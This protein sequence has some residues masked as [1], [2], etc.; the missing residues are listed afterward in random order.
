MAD[1]ATLGIQIKSSDI[2]KA[3]KALDK[4][5]ESAE[6][7]EKASQKIADS[8]SAYVGA[9]KTAS[10]EESKRQKS[11]DKMIESLRQQEIRLREG[12]GALTD[13][14]LSLL[15]ATESERKQAQELSKKIQLM[16]ESNKAIYNHTN[17]LNSLVSKV[18]ALAAAYFSLNS[19][20]NFA[21][22]L[23]NTAKI[24]DN[25]KYSLLAVSD[26]GEQAAE[27]YQYLE[28]EANRL[29]QSM[30][31]NVDSFTGFIASAKAAGLTAEQ[32]R[33]IYTGLNE[34]MTALHRT[35][36]QASQALY[37]LQQMLASGTVRA[38]ELNIQLANAIPGAVP[39]FAQA[40]GKTTKELRD[41]MKDGLVPAN[42]AVIQFTDYLSGK[43]GASA[44]AA[45]NSVQGSLNKMDNALYNLKK[46]I[47]DAMGDN[48]TGIIKDATN[49]LIDFTNALKT[50]EGKQ[51]I[52]DLSTT[53]KEAASGALKLAS[54]L[55]SVL[56]YANLR[57]LSGTM[58]QAA[59]LSKKGMLDI[60]KF[61]TSS[62][63]ERQRMV[64]D[65]LK[66]ESELQ[67]AQQETIKNQKELLKTI[68]DTSI[69]T[70]NTGDA[71][72]RGWS[73][74]IGTTTQVTDKMNEKTIKSITEKLQEQAITAGKTGVEKVRAE[75]E[76]AN[77]T[78]E[79]K[80]SILALAAANE[81]K[82]NARKNAEKA[83]RKAEQDAEAAI[84]KAEAA[85]K[86]RQGR[87]D[88]I[89][90][91]LKDQI[92]TYKQGKEVSAE[93]ALQH[94][95]ATPQIIEYAKALGREL[96]QMKAIN[97]AQKEYDALMAKTAPD[98]VDLKRNEAIAILNEQFK[99][100][101]KNAD[102][103]KKSLKQINDY[104]DT[105]EL[106]EYETEV[107]KLAETIGSLKTSSF[108]NEMADGI[109]NAVI[110][111]R[112]LND[113]LEKNKDTYDDIKKKREEAY[114]IANEDEREKKIKELDEL[115]GKYTASQLSGYRQLFGTIS[116]LYGENTK[117]REALHKIEMAFAAA[118][119]AMNLQ[120]TIS[121]AYVA[122]TTQGAGD[123]YTAFAR[124]A[125]MTA[126]MAGIVSAAGG[127]LSGG[128]SGGGAASAA[129]STSSSTVLGGTEGSQSISN[130]LD[131]MT[132]I[133]SKQYN[134]LK[135]INT[136]VESLNKNITGLV[137]SIVRNADISTVQG[138]VAG[139]SG[140]ASYAQDS[141]ARYSSIIG[142]ATSISSDLMK[143]V[144]IIGNLLGNIAGFV[145]DAVLGI[146]NAVFG[147]SKK[148]TILAQGLEVSTGKIS[149]LLDGMG[150]DIQKFA[151]IKVKK[152][153]GLFGSDKTYYKT[154]Y[155]SLGDEN[156][157]KMFTN[158]FKNM[159]ETMVA[160]SKGLNLGEDNLKQ[161]LSYSFDIG[162]LD[163]KGLDADAINKAV[164]EAI[165]T[166][167][168]VAIQALFGEL[169]G[170]YQEVGEGLLETAIRVV[171]EKGVVEDILSM[172]NQAF[173][174]AAIPEI[175][176]AT[177]Q[178]IIDLAG[179]IKQ[180]QESSSTYFNEF[181]T[182]AEKQ[183][184]LYSQ[185]SGAMASINLPMAENRDA[186]R[187]M[188]ESLDLNT[189]SGREQYATLLNLSEAADKYYDA[190]ESGEKTT[191]DNSDAITSM[192]ADTQ[193]AIDQMDMSEFD[194]SIQNIKDNTEKSIKQL[195][196]MGASESDLAVIREYG[197][198]QIK[199]LTDAQNQQIADEKAASESL[200]ASKQLEL[201]ILNGVAT[202][203]DKVNFQRQQELKTL[204]ESVQGIQQAIWAR[205]DEIAAN[206]KAARIASEK[207][208][209]ELRI[210]ELTMSSS[211]FLA[212]KRQLE[213]AAMD[214]SLKPLQERI[215]Q[216]EDEATAN[217]KAA[218]IADKRQSLEIELLNLTGKSA[219]AVAI[220]RKI[221]LASLDDSLKPLQE[222]VWALQ[223][224]QSATGNVNENITKKYELELRLLELTG[225]TAEAAAIKREKE[226][227]GLD[228]TN[229]D[230]QKRIWSLEDESEAIQKATEIANER[231][232]LEVQLLEL[233]GK[234]KEAVA[235]QRQIELASID[236]S[237]KA[238]QERIWQLQDEKEA[239]DAAKAAA[240][241]LADREK[242]YQEQVLSE[243]IGLENELLQ[244]MG[245]TTELRKRELESLDESNR[246][247][248][249]RIWQL[250]EF[251]EI[252]NLFKTVQDEVFNAQKSLQD[253]INK[254]TLS[255][256]EMRNIERENI[257]NGT[258]AISDK[259]KQLNLE[260]ELLQKQFDNS[261]VQL[262]LIAS[263]KEAIEAEKKRLYDEYNAS[264]KNDYSVF[265]KFSEK[266]A[267]LFKQMSALDEES[268]KTQTSASDFQ[269]ALFGLNDKIEVI[270]D[271][272]SSSANDATLALQE[273][274]WALQDEAEAA[275]KAKKILEDRKSLEI[276]LLEAQGKNTEALAI[277]RE[278][279]LSVMDESLRSIQNQIWAIEDKN[280]IEAELTSKAQ[281]ISEERFELEI[282]LLELQGKKTEATALR[283]QKELLSIDESN[284][285]LQERIWQLEDEVNVIETVSTAE[286]ER[287]TLEIRYAE[288]TMS[289]VEYLAFTRK[290]ELDNIDFSNKSLQERIWALEDEAEA[291]DLAIKA[292]QDLT[293][294][295]ESIA[296]E[297]LSLEKR[298]LELQGDTV[299][300]RKLELESIN[301]SN[302][303]LQEKIWALE[304][305]QAAMPK[306]EKTTYEDEL[307]KYQGDIKSVF[308]TLNEELL[309]LVKT[310]EELRN[311]E[312]EKMKKG[313]LAIKEK[314]SLIEKEQAVVEKEKKKVDRG[315][316][317]GNDLLDM[318]KKGDL[319]EYKKVFYNGKFFDEGFV[320]EILLK[321]EID[322]II[323]QS[324]SLGDTYDDLSKTINDYTTDLK[325][326]TAE[327]E[328]AIDLQKQIW[329]IQDAMKIAEEKASL[330]MKLA[331]LTMSNSEYTALVRQKELE[332]IN[333]SNKSIQIRIW[334]L[335]DE[336]EQI[337]KNKAIS[338]EK[339]ALEMRL[340]E[341]TLSET[342]YLALSRQ[343]EIL[344]ID[345]SNRSIQQA[346][347]AKEDEIKAND[348]LAEQAEKAA[349]L[350]KE[351]Q[352]LEI[353][354]L[355]EQGFETEAI[356]IQR[357]LELSAMDASLRGIQERIWILQDE[358]TATE[359]L[360]Q[361]EKDRIDNLKDQLKTAEDVLKQSIDKQIESYQNL[362][363]EATGIL[364][365]AKNDLE[366]A[367]N[368]EQEK[369]NKNH[370]SLIS[371]LTMRLEEANDAA[372]ILENTFKS[373]SDARK[374][375][376]ESASEI[377]YKEAQKQLILE[378]ETARKG[379]LS[380]L[381]KVIPTL[382]VL[383]SPDQE[384]YKSQED[385]K[386]DFFKTYNALS[387]LE[388][389]SGT[390]LSEQQQVINN[391]ELQIETENINHEEN[392]KALE[393]QYN[394]V[395]GLDTSVKTF[396]QSI[397]DYQN[398]QYEADGANALLK[399]Q[400]EQ[401]NNQLN[402][403]LNINNS[404][405][406]VEEAIRQYQAIAA[407]IPT[408]SVSIPGYA[409]GGM[410]EGTYVVGE[411]GAEILTTPP[412]KITSNSDIKSM[413][414]DEDVK[415]IL[416]EI[417][418]EISRG[419]FNIAKNTQETAKTLKKFDY[420]GMPETRV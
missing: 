231:K 118:E 237:N 128:G 381:N 172:T 211:D 109:N 221:E 396:K 369:I 350:A 88:S 187:A 21:G 407:Q 377:S 130:S 195:T 40:M 180:L 298:L 206:E 306:E 48:T 121:A 373:F 418:D 395:I 313:S 233:E 210:N 282:N 256:E 129:A 394:A 243:R 79:E 105:K 363:D 82:E 280:K 185:L 87:I 420:D 222:R 230:L 344:S 327:E 348:L 151:D 86:A 333:E 309:T 242:Q 267:D 66:K 179:G 57:S 234:S 200:R 349:N 152:E 148:T 372:G 31:A 334:Q 228:A 43:F 192:V 19:I 75:L 37:A 340:A 20:K 291:S 80:K 157:S 140:G 191:K 26:S 6:K 335:E 342:E 10:N 269:K 24:A 177:T 375:M 402:A 201:D 212:K 322:K 240:D 406:S 272:L 164:S 379:D 321:E 77:A 167:G 161:I 111:M 199:E 268:K 318:L 254:Y 408:T 341:L 136:G 409:S 279:E 137:T 355:K 67:K 405:L 417:K 194:K 362:A 14:K 388:K 218:E 356:A 85:E 351:K 299:A 312:I 403:L 225:K 178:S 387:E 319:G 197:N 45:S 193:K 385:Y 186:F 264:D 58:E 404:V 143:N 117:E 112:D 389:I 165:S 133:Q 174:N 410:A 392:I 47:V 343:K 55:G 399:Q 217:A 53:I 99:D 141:L 62:A 207:S 175:A 259:L 72:N 60:Q 367:Y 314:I 44:E 391:L 131:F 382:E 147:G 360:D 78:D 173:D 307:K 138:A 401:L 227:I 162:K 35:P 374:S 3:A 146:S 261:Q 241:Q 89:I 366:K 365:K 301:A 183:S 290:L 203:Q 154:L 250:Q 294:A 126:L 370:E 246:S 271:G 400:T 39:M 104:Y 27:T 386:R 308:E 273:H 287:K 330:E 209:L 156:V 346:I 216:L 124:V 64:D 304:D 213:L 46:S 248:Q 303:S 2:L 288:L 320:G 95:N 51:F 155:E 352:S 339:A 378:L 247:L 91:K 97:K 359:K 30:T 380:G 150:T 368:A 262:G 297:R 224:E 286:Q 414:N 139:E 116:Q 323:K 71:F 13:Y 29:G 18:S 266:S 300:L 110:S 296:S 113:Y 310:T 83:Q 56:Q 12:K 326:L 289:A 181:F 90:Q 163:L 336:A 302:R 202:E 1:I 277:Q 33:K 328:A 371:S 65:V 253:E 9:T 106:K 204:P 331:E 236:D 158:V 393:R 284:R 276:K 337:S 293:A 176:L 84:K 115:E 153:G 345:E 74:I 68:T 397:V 49:A 73:P 23:L 134:E 123:P 107:S 329:A 258:N 25:F 238:I 7:A 171:S 144:P 36:E 52:A 160:I 324:D 17:S 4:L 214:D 419:N 270:T 42:E 38:Q 415:R 108:G 96:D 412:A 168:D 8:M 275:E 353:E 59:E 278:K 260:K 69:E 249:E 229:R 100:V 416:A 295:R 347:W 265:R 132:D 357:Q 283:R 166:S 70:K 263:K 50:E 305:E 22:E 311:I 383:T 145:D 15:G 219:E 189:E 92:A 398:A 390:Q 354:L 63:L 93:V 184:R 41:L 274:L 5:A 239:S 245:N 102:E 149:D 81:Q 169:I 32:S 34:A 315:V 208:A 285:S 292:E 226:L 281:K 120:K 101:A 103:Y 255:S 94:E 338:E 11:I 205:E 98:Q 384:L 142:I 235:L 127:S 252:T 317:Y 361:A 220:Q 196:D 170:K 364:E 159:G 316:R 76:A 16:Q 114:A 358:K 376:E 190:L 257:K 182:D 122:I 125:A 28:K 325:A 61:A 411:R 413:L 332:T 215:Y 223:D 119:I 135:D 251:E 232:N 198:K 54:A 244:L 188:V